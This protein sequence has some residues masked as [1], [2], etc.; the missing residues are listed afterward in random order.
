MSVGTYSIEFQHKVINVKAPFDTV[1]EAFMSEFPLIDPHM[2]SLLHSPQ[3]A[4]A[5]RSLGQ[6]KTLRTFSMIDYTP[7]LAAQGSADRGFEIHI[8]DP[9]AKLDILR[10]SI[11]AAHLIPKRIIVC[12]SGQRTALRYTSDYERLNYDLATTGGDMEALHQFGEFE[13]ALLAELRRVTSGLG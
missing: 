8:G 2:L 7:A 1:F 10:R 11:I 5:A 13:D 6:G 3:P 4:F 12:P 9:L